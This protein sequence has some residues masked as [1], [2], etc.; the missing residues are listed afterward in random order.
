MFYPRNN[1]PAYNNKY[2]VNVDYGGL[3]RCMV[4]NKS[5]GC[6]LANC[7]GYSYGRWL[8]ETGATKCNLP[9]NDA[10]R[11]LTMDH[12]YETGITARKGAVICFGGGWENRG[13]VGIVE[14][15]YSDGSILVSQSNYGGNWWEQVKLY[16]PN[17]SYPEGYGLYLQGFIYNPDVEDQPTPS[18]IKM[19]GIDISEHNSYDIQLE[20]YDFVIIRACWGTN[21]DP[22]ADMWRRLCEEK[23]IPYG[24]YLYTYALSEQDAIDEAD[25]IANVIK[26]WNIQLGV[27]IDMENDSYKQSKGSWNPDLCS[28]VCRT[29]CT[30]IQEYGYYTGI[31]ASESVFGTYIKGCDNFDKWVA[32]WGT[33][34]G[35][36][37]RDTSNMGTLLQYTSKG[38]ING[39]PLD[40]NISYC[41]LDHYKSY[42]ATNPVEDEK[43]E[44]GDE[45]KPIPDNPE[46]IIP[47][48]DYLFKMSDKV[49]DFL[50]FLIH[51][52]PRFLLLYIALS[53]AWNWTLTIPIIATVEAVVDFISSVVRQSKIGYERARNKEEMKNG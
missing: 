41:D 13:H 33:N 8:E 34:N 11:W 22:K 3:N 38:G 53:N 6:V 50:N 26:D 39:A 30:K 15:V 42:P 29:F 12:G 35:Q 17:Y 32:S 9:R 20:K 7:T 40:C 19:Y 47:D 25:Y 4:I 44:G 2:Y 14:E 24:V 49:Y 21:V 51:I 48:D 46:I 18:K 10:G 5:T 31:Y 23:K 28:L 1:A 37:Q 27:W 16:P 36:I 43:D 45:M 52:I